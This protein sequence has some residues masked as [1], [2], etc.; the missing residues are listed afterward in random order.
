MRTLSLSLA[1]LF[2]AGCKKDKDDTGDSKN[3]DGPVGKVDRDGDGFNEED[4]C[5]DY[6]ASVNPDAEE[7]CDDVDNDCDDEIDEG[8]TAVFYADA[9]GDG[10]GDD[11]SALEACVAPTGY[12]ED[13]TDC[14]DTSDDTNPDAAERCDGEDNDCDGTVDEDVQATWYADADDDGFGDPAGATDDCDPPE[15]FVENADDCDDTTALANPDAEEICDEIDNDCDGSVDEDVLSTFYADADG[16]GF[17]DG[18]T[19][20]EACVP[21]TDFVEDDTDCDDA[22][23]GVNPGATELCDGVD[24]DCSG[25][26]D[27]DYA[28][29]ASIWYPD[30]DT[31]GFG[32]AAGSVET[33]CDQPSGYVADATDCDDTDFAVNPDAVEV[34]GDLTDNDCDGN[35]DDVDADGDG[36]V[37]DACAGGSD[38]DDDDASVFPGATDAWYD[39]VDADCAGDSDYDADADGYDSDSYGGT[40]CDDTTSAAYPGGPDTWYDGIDGDCAGDSDYDADADGYDLDAFGG[41]DCDDTDAAINPDAIEVWYDGVDSDCSGDVSFDDYDADEDGFVALAYGGSD[42]DDTD[43]SIY[44][45]APDP[46][47]DGVDSDCAGDSDYDYDGDGFDSAIYGGTD[48]A[49]LNPY[50]YPGATERWY[51]GIDQDCAGDSD[52]DADADGYDSDA[53]GGTDCD[54]TSALAHPGGTEVCGDGV[55]NDCDGTAENV[56]ADGDGYYPLACGGGDCADGNAAR[57]PGATEVWYDGVDQDC[58]G[59][60]DDDADGDGFQSAYEDSDGTLGTDCYDFAAEMYPGAGEVLDDGFDNDCDGVA[61]G[62]TSQGLSAANADLSIYGDATERLSQGDPG[63]ARAG[64]MNNDGDDDFVVGSI[65]DST[66]AS[67]SGA[68]Y[69][70]FGPLSAGSATTINTIA[71]VKMTGESASDYAGRSVVGLGDVSGDGIDDLAVAALND[72]D[73]GT[74]AGAVYVIEG[75]LAAGSFSLS[76]ADAK[77]IGAAGGDVFADAAWAGDM[78]GDGTNDILVGAQGNDDAGADAGAAYLFFGGSLSGSVDAGTSADATLTGE[79]AGDAAGS[80]VGGAG[81]FNGDGNDDLLIGALKDDDGAT[82]AGAAYIVFG[83]VTT[84]F[85]LALAD[86]KYTGVAASSG[87]GQFASLVG[88]GDTNGDGVDDVLIGANTESAAAYYTGAAYLIQ[89]STSPGSG[90][91]SLSTADAKLEGYGARDR[92]GD[93]VGRAGDVDGDGLSDI[94]IGAGYSSYDSD[95]GGSVYVMTGP[96]SGTSTVQNAYFH[97]WVSEDG[98]RAAGRGVGDLDGDGLDD[99][100][101]GAWRAGSQTGELHLFFAGGF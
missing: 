75:P 43:A 6:D 80:A 2:V 99:V 28:A 18:A 97:T 94:I 87:V 63:F 47:Y 84:D 16:D 98:A 12:V 62:T 72:D 37:S 48:C 17:G 91:L 27:D 49:D 76:T 4:D 30:V 95:Q 58:G 46:V 83:P 60:D 31:D 92:A 85:S 55:D 9:D 26:P 64:D 66:S 50:R 10:Y 90:T 25:T 38:C 23:P 86:L 51:D 89:G 7:I 40:D 54:D 5:D 22:D 45:G 100:M 36:I 24:N 57:N 34:C 101:M 52:Y 82:D 77:L 78:N 44:P 93:S 11:E 14:D 41:E 3:G 68:A 56:D 8:V 1:L 74:D 67:R 13:N 65:F 61:A 79:D 71:D 29:D 21:P 81:D 35:T 69:V 42:C 32:D 39:G 96:F 70:V 15:G 53:Y 33:A 59:D 19:T 88:A 20:V 73:G